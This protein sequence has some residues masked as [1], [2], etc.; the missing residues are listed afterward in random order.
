MKKIISQIVKFLIGLFDYTFHRNNNSKIIFYHD[1]S[2]TYTYM[3]T[4]LGLIERH[5]DII[6]HEG[7][8]VVEKI[9]S[10]F[11]QVMICFD[12]GWEGI[13][14][15]KDF[16]ISKGI[17]PT[18]FISN[19]LIGKPGYLNVAQI[20]ELESLGFMFEGHSWSHYNLPSFSESELRHE[21]S[22]SKKEIEKI[23]G[24]SIEAICFPQGR[25]DDRVI[26]ISKEAGYCYLYS[27]LA[28]THD[29]LL[30]THGVYC[31]ILVQ[32]SS[33]AYFKFQLCSDSPYMQKRTLRLHYK[34]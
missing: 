21:L 14:Y 10:P 7:F 22:D 25:F 29:A 20:K 33:P 13:Y 26:R 6:N 15:S 9:T 2:Q 30:A 24:H 27:S 18:I 17:R 8:E 32:Y 31:R 34:H 1:V 16:F 23:L 11:K 4:D 19:S 28:A 5:L 3:G 12:D